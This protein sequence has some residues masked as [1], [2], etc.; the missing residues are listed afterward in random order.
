MKNY[1]VITSIFEP[2]EA[3]YSFS[4]MKNYQLVVV[5][6]KK[7]PENWHCECV[8]YLSIK[9]QMEIG[10]RLNKLLPFNHYCRKMMGYLFS[11]ANGADFI[12]DTDD[13]NIP[14]SNWNF[15]AFK[16]AFSAIPKNKG[17]INIYQLYTKNKIQVP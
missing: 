4:K 5:G 1:I 12:V 9:K 13:D 3:V 17:F 8:E 10:S 6:D 16:E 15:P 11:I 2:T 14:K 7:T